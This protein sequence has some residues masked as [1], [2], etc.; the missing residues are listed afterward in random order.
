MALTRRNWLVAAGAASLPMAAPATALAAETEASAQTR[1]PPEPSSVALLSKESFP[2]IKN[3]TYM[4][5]AAIHPVSEGSIRLAEKAALAEFDRKPGDFFPDGDRVISHFAALI[6][7]APEEVEFVPSTSVGESFI[8]AALGLPQPGAHVISDV[9][10]Y[11]GAQMMYLEMQKRGVEVTFIPMSQD[12]KIPLEEYERQIRPGKT[13]L[14]ALSATS[15][16]NGFTQD[17]KSLCQ[18]ARTRDIFVHADMIQTIGNTPVDVKAMGV[19]SACAG[20]YKWLMARGT[21]FLYVN[22]A[23]MHKLAP[24]FYHISNYDFPLPH[25]TPSTKMSWPDT[26]MYPYDT[27]GKQ[28][29]DNYVPKKGARGM[30]SLGYEPNLSTLAGLEYS[31]PYLEQVGLERLRA[32]RKPMIERL[33]EQLPR[34]GYRLLTPADSESPIVT[35][36]VRDAGRLDPFFERANVKV[37]TRWN[38]VRISVSLFNDMEDVERVLAAFPMSDRPSLM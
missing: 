9:L 11:D 27:P 21:A 7:A 10:H 3:K 1:G 37:T 8:A 19:D 17:L 28:I 25:E 32:H 29:V 33:K 18:I 4:N 38:H 13:K 22:A 20:T 31:L 34:K 6:N 36:A 23:S 12:G 26:H 2:A 16:L 15:M 30:F 35:V 14:I 24:P 5:C